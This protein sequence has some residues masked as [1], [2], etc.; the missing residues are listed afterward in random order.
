MDLSFTNLN[1]FFAVALQDLH[2]TEKTKSY[3]INL[4]SSYQKPTYDLSQENI[5]LVFLEGR[6]T[7]DF[8]LLQQCADWI[9]FVQSMMP[10]H[11]S[12]DDYYRDIGRLSYYTCYKLINR[13]WLIFE[14]LSDRFEA[15]EK[16]A[17][18]KLKK[19]QIK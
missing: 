15:L 2:C 12:S 19:I 11:L 3:L 14:E 10:G 13:K 6:S 16:E 1:D 5:T 18:Q 7:G 8:H 9:F 4:Y 17:S